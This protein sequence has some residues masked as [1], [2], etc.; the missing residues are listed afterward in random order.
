MEAFKT[1][2]RY[3]KLCLRIKSL[4]TLTKCKVYDACVLPTLLYGSELWTSL[5]KHLQKLNSFIIDIFGRVLESLS[6]HSG[7]IIS[8]MKQ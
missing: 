2:E 4:T 3:I 1:L 6:Q 5:K 8:Q 7:K